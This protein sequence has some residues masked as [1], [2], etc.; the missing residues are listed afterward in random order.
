MRMGMMDVNHGKSE[1]N[2]NNKHKE[3]TNDREHD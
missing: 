2:T 1:H 3:H